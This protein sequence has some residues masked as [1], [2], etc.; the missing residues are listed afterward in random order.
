[1]PTQPARISQMGKEKE[2][3]SGQLGLGRL[4]LEMELGVWAGSGQPA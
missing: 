4:V 2:V 1:M 3:M